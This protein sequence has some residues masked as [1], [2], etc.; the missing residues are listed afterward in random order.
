MDVIKTEPE[1]DPLTVQPCDDAVKEEADPSPDVPAPYLL[2]GDFNASHHSWGSNSDDD[3]GNKIAEEGN[4]LDLNIPKIKEEYVDDSYNHTSKIKF[5]EIILPNNFPVVKCET[6]L[7][8]RHLFCYPLCRKNHVTW[9]QW[10]K[11]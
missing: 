4:L 6:E 8:M 11:M 1:V 3:R 5:E 2:V 7:Q 10:Q 9:G